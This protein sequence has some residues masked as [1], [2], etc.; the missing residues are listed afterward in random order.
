MGIAA[1]MPLCWIG[2]PEPMTITSTYTLRMT[3]ANINNQE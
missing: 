2:D 3:S 1:S